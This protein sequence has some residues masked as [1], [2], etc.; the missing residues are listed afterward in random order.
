[1]GW[2]RGQAYAQDL[3]DRVL[4]CDGQSA[5]AVADRFG[6]SASYVI[7]ARQRRDR[8][9][10]VSAGRQMS[11]TPAKLNGHDAAL[12]E[13]VLRCPDATLAEHCAWAKAELG[14]ALGTTAMWK[15]LRALQLT[16]KKSVWSPPSRHVHQL[17]KPV[18]FGRR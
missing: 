11:H 10:D 2:R 12:Q 3:R 15:R 16:L 18:G 8:L 14:I 4:A 6:V 7:K 5:A 1:M 17:P 13:R 9:G